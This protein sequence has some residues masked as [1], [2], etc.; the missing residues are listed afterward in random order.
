MD[1]PPNYER[2]VAVRLIFLILSIALY[3][4]SLTQ[5]CYVHADTRPGDGLLGIV[6]LLFGWGLIPGEGVAWLANP[7][8]WGAWLTSLMPFTRWLTVTIAAVAL[9][10]SL[11]FLLVHEMMANEGG[12]RAAVTGY[13]PGY[14]L[15]IV[16]IVCALIGAI[17]E[18]ILQRLADSRRPHAP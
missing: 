9:G 17:V 13:G 15:W 8:L 5:V 18:W 3:L 7:L 12:S 16:S 4:T 11:S 1:V 10:F 14:W 2:F 6:A